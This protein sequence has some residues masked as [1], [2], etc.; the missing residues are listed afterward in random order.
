MDSLRVFELYNQIGGILTCNSITNKC[1]VEST[2]LVCCLDSSI[3]HL[4]K[5][6]NDTP[7]D[8]IEPIFD[9]PA[10]K[11]YEIGGYKIV[12]ETKRIQTGVLK[13]QY[14]EIF[15]IVLHP[16]AIGIKINNIDN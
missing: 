6:I 16:Q 9:I 15:G 4:Q 3:P 7:K 1:S 5:L 2:N 8:K 11:T 14:N 10:T 12:R 13:A